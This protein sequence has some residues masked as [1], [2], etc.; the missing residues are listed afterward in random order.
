MSF[1]SMKALFMVKESV[2]NQHWTSNGKRYNIGKLYSWARQNG[3]EVEVI[4]LGWLKSGYLKTKT[5]EAKD[6]PAFWARAEAA[7]DEPILV[8]HDDK[9]F[10]IADGNHRYARAD[11]D[12]KR[13]IEGYV[14][15]ECDLPEDAVEPKT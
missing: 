10:W 1:P 4:P 8:V 11:R 5:D 2:D 3:H 14:V 9:N 15:R 7:G 13:N 6:S 12:G